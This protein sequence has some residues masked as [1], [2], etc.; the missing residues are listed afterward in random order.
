MD[1]IMLWMLFQHWTTFDATVC[2]T[3]SSST[4]WKKQKHTMV[5]SL[6]RQWDGWAGV[7]YWIL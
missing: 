3:V 1:I 7:Q 4:F 5:M 6:I 2:P